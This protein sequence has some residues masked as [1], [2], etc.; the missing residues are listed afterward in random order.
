[1]RE[2]RTEVVAGTFNGRPATVDIPII[3]ADAAPE[4]AE[5]LRR[6]RVAATLGRCPCGAR[7]QSTPVVERAAEQSDPNRPTA[8]APFNHRADCPAHD[9]PLSAALAAW[10][11]RKG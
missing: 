5:G 2:I 11:N 10:Q 8:H 6:R 9:T 3:P 4:L 7:R 1:M